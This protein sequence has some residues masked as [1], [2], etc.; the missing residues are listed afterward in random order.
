[1]PAINMFDYNTKARAYWWTIVVL[2][3]GAAVYGVAGALKLDSGSQLGVL[4]LTIAVVPAGLGAIGIPGTKSSITP[5]DLFVFLA[6]LF[7]GVPAAILVAIVDGVAGSFRTSRRWTSRLG[8]PAMLA[9]AIF[10]SGGLFEFALTWQQRRGW[11]GTASL[12]GTLL[13]FSLVHFAFSSILMAGQLAVKRGANLFK[14]WWENYAWASL[15]FAASASAAGLIYISIDHY[16]VSS[17][18]AAGPLL[19]IIFMTCRLYF[20]QANERAKAAET[21]NLQA[22]IHLREM[23]ESEERFRSAFNHA[24]IGMALVSPEGN[25]LQVNRALCALVGYSET[26]LL[27]TDFQ[28]L[29]HPDDVELAARPVAQLLAGNL[30][31]GPVELRYVHKFG[32][33]V[34]ALLSTSLVA[35]PRTRLPR[36]IFQIQD[37]TDRKRAQEQLTHN[38]FHDA[39]TGLPNRVLFIDHVK[40]ALA[41]GQRRRGQVFAVLFLDLDRFKLINDSLGHLTG[42]QLLV[43][44]SRRLESCARPG[45]TVARLGGDEFTILLEEIEDW[46]EAVALAQQVQSDLTVPFKL[47][48]D[49][50]FISAS[51]GITLSSEGYQKPDEMLRDADTAM[52]HAKSQGTARYALFNRGM[53][54]RARKLLQLETDLRH[55]LDRREL[56]LVYQPIVSLQTGKLTGFEA[57]ARWQHPRRGLISP[58]DFIPVAEETGHIIPIGQWILSEAC[59][60]MNEWR[61]ESASPFPLTMSVNLSG[62]QFAQAHII[63]QILLTLDA[64]NLAAGQLRLEITESVLMD[65]IDAAITTLRQLRDCG[66]RL[67]IDDFGTGYSSLSYLRRLPLDTLKIDRSFVAGMVEDME[68]GEIVRAI[69]ALAKTLGLSVVAEGIETSEQLEQLRQLSCHD[70]QG[71]LFAR[72]LT[73]EKAAEM[74]KLMG[75]WEAFKPLLE[76]STIDDHEFTGQYTM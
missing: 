38:A 64:N 73:A 43:A 69:I 4:A 26:E 37:I 32:N 56:F 46:N 22:E 2:G 15:P 20:K 45:D 54:A 57:L 67:S 7:W 59:R 62:K 40:L 14:L 51:I 33:P 13:L 10:A 11:N 17:L 31:S 29:T 34:W 66:I 53:H 63:E 52:Y 42:D 23:E 50:I 3:A 65:N 71:F 61:N 72:P 36:L 44:I 58:D 48:D 35:D 16:G 55:A 18:L 41:R 47:G 24:A 68:N 5:G 9:V 8:S 30:P 75:T 27:S 6:L 70:G 49:E 21:Q 19:A 74:V 39:L 1:M 76:A 12:L 28:S 60:Q 25:W